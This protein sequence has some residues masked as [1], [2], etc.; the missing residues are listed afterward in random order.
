MARCADALAGMIKGEDASE[1]DFID[2]EAFFNLVCL[3]SELVSI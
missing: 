1:L 3:K 2:L